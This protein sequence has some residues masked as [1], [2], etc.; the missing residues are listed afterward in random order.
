MNGMGSLSLRNWLRSARKIWKN[1]SR[2][3]SSSLGTVTQNSDLFASA[4]YWRSES[5][6]FKKQ[7]NIRFC[8]FD[9][10]CIWFAPPVFSRSSPPSQIAEV[11]SKLMVK[12]RRL[13][14][15]YSDRWCFAMTTQAVLH[16]VRHQAQYKL[17]TAVLCSSPVFGVSPYQAPRV[18]GS[19]VATNQH[20]SSFSPGL[21]G[22]NASEK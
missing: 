11:S 7:I 12:G 15:S 22:N 16:L 20:V 5:W 13:A 21:W 1:S 6:I 17:S 19:W 14:L 10:F 9:A 2:T 18:G 3:M 8:H 4:R